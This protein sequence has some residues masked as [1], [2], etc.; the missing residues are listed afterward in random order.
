[1]QHREAALIDPLTGV[2]NRR[3]FDAGVAQ[4]LARARRD[5]SST[6]LLLLDLDHFKA[7]NDTWGHQVGDHVLQAVARAV[8]QQLRR[9]DVVAR[10]GGEE[11]AVALAGSGADQAAML[12]E[13]MRRAVAALDIRRGE[14]SIGLTVSIGVAALRAADSLD[15]LFSRA[16]AALYRAKTAGRN[17]VEFASA[18]RTIA[19]AET[20]PRKMAVSRAA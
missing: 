12:A 18:P 19:E 14:A 3:G 13:A 10:L 6:A 16:D 20:P 2:A 15:A 5:G 4:M 11:F 9:G 1:M 17:R 7:V 8:E